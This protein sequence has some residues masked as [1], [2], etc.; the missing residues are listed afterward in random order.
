MFF[1]VVQVASKWDCPIDEASRRIM[2]MALS[3]WKLKYAGYLTALSEF[4]ADRGQPFQTTCITM[5]NWLVM[6]EQGME[7]DLSDLDLQ[8][9]FEMI[10]DALQ[11]KKK[12]GEKADLAAILAEDDEKPW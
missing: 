4:C 8:A 11:E 2:N 5:R 10:L 6:H 7:E 12:H 1:A 9:R 3:G